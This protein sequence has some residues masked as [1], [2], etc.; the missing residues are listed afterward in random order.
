MKLRQLRKKVE[1]ML[2]DKK[3]SKKEGTFLRKYLP[4]IWGYEPSTH[5]VN[6]DNRDNKA[7]NKIIIHSWFHGMLHTKAYEFV[8]SKGQTFLLEY[9]KWLEKNIKVKI[10]G[11]KKEIK[12]KYKEKENEK[13]KIK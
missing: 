9:V 2:K 5:H 10:K 3:L 1:S 4:I 6:G 12:K 8:V 11:I 7:E 13:S